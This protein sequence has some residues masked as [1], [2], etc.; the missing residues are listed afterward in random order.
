MKHLIKQYLDHGI[1]RRRLVSGLSAFGM[2]TV[3]GEGDGAISCPI[4][5]A[6]AR[7]PTR[8]NPCAR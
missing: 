4:G 8:P 6:G 5:H 1:S 3:D 2:S 7:P